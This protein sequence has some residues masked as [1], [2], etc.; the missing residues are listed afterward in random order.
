MV[1]IL[2]ENRTEGFIHNLIIAAGSN[3]VQMEKMFE[4]RAEDDKSEESKIY[5][6]KL[7]QNNRRTRLHW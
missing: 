1:K 3:P 6:K 2:S 5:L 7:F 4:E